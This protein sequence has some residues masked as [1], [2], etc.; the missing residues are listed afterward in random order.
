VSERISKGKKEKNNTNRTLVQ[1]AKVLTKK[2][3]DEQTC[4]YRLSDAIHERM[5]K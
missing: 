5:T 2:R 1:I 3:S 4:V